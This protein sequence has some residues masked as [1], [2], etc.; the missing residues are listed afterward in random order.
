[1]TPCAQYIHSLVMLLPRQCP[2]MRLLTRYIN[3]V[4]RLFSVLVCVFVCSPGDSIVPLSGI[5]SV[6]GVTGD[7]V[8]SGVQL[9]DE[10][11]ARFLVADVSFH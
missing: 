7:V 6:S 11:V 10:L 8:L 4:H 1:M 9:D 5:M 2:S 3:L